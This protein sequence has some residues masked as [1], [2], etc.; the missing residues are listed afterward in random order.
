[1]DVGGTKT[2]VVARREGAVVGDE[3]VLTE[4]WRTWRV[5]DDADGLAALTKRICG[6]IPQSFAIGAHGC[7]SDRQC[8]E[9]RTALAARLP[10]TIVR[11]V[12]DSELLVP[13]AGYTDGIGV[14]CG[15]GSIAVARSRDGRMLAAGGWGWIL[16]DEGSAAGLV[17]ESAKAIRGAVDADQLDD[18]LIPGFLEALGTSEVTKLGRTLNAVRGAAE[19]GRFA[20]V[21]F[22]AADRGSVLARRVIEDGATALAKLVAALAKRGADAS[23]VVAGGGVIA[24]QPLLWTAFQSAVAVVSPES[25]VVLLRDPPVV[26]AIALAERAL[27]STRIQNAD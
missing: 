19:W 9:L 2:R 16:G 7:D 6:G 12:N 15:T 20:T 21:V 24:E 22:D 17:R 25:R 11:V 14:V 26:G 10:A 3:T 1:M 13:A 23:V 8:D 18:P 27:Q 4:T 5:E